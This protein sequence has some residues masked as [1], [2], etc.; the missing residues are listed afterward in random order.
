MDF[1]L[2]QLNVARAIAPVDGPELADF[3]AL[4]DPV[5]ALGDAAPGFVWRLQDDS[6]DATSIRPFDDDRVIVN[7]TVWESIDALW[8]FVYSGRH[9]EVMRR[10]R[11]WFQRFGA[12]YLVLWWVQA[13]TIPT[14]DEA[15]ARL[16]HLD[17]HGPTP[18]AFTFKQRFDPEPA[19][20]Q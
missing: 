10:R 13:G 18:Q 6:G 5:N 17:A 12:P 9:L 11:E 4:L 1:H 2:A 19:L 20:A 16:E 8:N 14:V 15:K 7:L 3:M